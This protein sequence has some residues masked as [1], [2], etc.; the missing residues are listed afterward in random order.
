MMKVLWLSAGSGL[1]KSSVW[2]YNGG[3]WVASAQR[4]IQQE[5]K[6]DFA[7]AFLTNNTDDK[8][9]II[10]GT[11]YYPVYTKA[12]GR[13]KKM[14]TYYGG[15]KKINDNEF[16]IRI[17]QIIENFKPDIIQL[18]GME[19]A[20]ATI[21]GKTEIPIVVHL[22]GLLAPYD[23]AFF[24]IGLNKSNF[25]WPFSLNEWVLRNGYIFAKNSIHVRGNRERD[26]FKRVH[27]LMGRTEWDYEVSHLLAPQSQY[28]HVDEVMRPCFYEGIGKWQPHEGRTK[29]VITSTI[30]QTIYKGLDL[31]L[32]AASLLEHETDIDFEWRVVGVGSDS[33]YV[34]FFE[35]SVEMKTSRVS[36]LG[37]LNAEQ[38]KDNLLESDVY[39]HP[40][41][42]DNSPNSVC[43]AQ[44]LGLP[45]I[46]TGVG[47]VMS[48]VEHKVSGLIVPAN[49]P[50]EL[51]FWLKEISENL[52]M[53]ASLGKEASAVAQKRHDREEIKKQMLS[54]YQT[55][56]DK[57]HNHKNQTMS[58]NN[59]IHL[60]LATDGTNA[61]GKM[62]G[63]KS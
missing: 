63:G 2:G 23:N 6:V 25:V 53:A 33:N 35:K 59:N 10:N 57:H 7:L 11:H 49:A 32:K 13:W 55:I 5:E 27:Y 45:V 60:P 18:F 54:T 22:Q 52:T 39:V 62:G 51:A 40:S 43:E 1:Y 29:F 42:I 3:G 41:Y 12:P 44:M 31:I 14:Q 16:V 21:L 38:L 61:L 19:N 28:F 46:A 56:L 8:E 30:S 50:Y 34:K 9:E 20:M 36:Y 48:L 15:Y 17:Q 4:L 58:N 26:L 37:V 24:P 47:G